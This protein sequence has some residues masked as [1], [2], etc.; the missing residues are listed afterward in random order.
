M[1]YEY[2]LDYETYSIKEIEVLVDFLSYLED[3]GKHPDFCLFK[4]KYDLYRKTL[5]SVQEEKRID[6]EFEK[7]SGISIYRTARGLGL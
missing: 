4:T 7:L 3:N 1:D 5:N 2:P 6:R